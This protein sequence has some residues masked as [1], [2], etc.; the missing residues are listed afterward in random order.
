M[1]LFADAK[2]KNL[3]SKVAY[4]HVTENDKHQK[5]PALFWTKDGSVEARFSQIKE[6]FLKH[7]LVI[8][9]SISGMSFYPI[10]I[11]PIHKSVTVTTG[12]NPSEAYGWTDTEPPV[13]DTD[14]K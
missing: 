9:D 11:D 13:I 12:D 10:S 1:K 4:V 6:A 3:C 5:I 2:D 8:I 14:P 7:Q